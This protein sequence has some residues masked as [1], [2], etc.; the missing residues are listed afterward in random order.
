MNKTCT[1]CGTSKPLFSF[2]NHPKAADGLQSQ[3]KPCSLERQRIARV[4][5]PCNSCSQP[6]ESDA[7]KWARVCATC[8]TKCN[9]CG[10]LERVKNQRICAS[11]Q[12]D[13]DRERKSPEDAKIRERVTRIKTKYRA[14]PAFASALAVFRHCEACG[15][16][17]SR[18][19]EIHV[20]HCHDT[21]KIRG[22]L[23][24]NCNA[25][26]GHIGDS[27]DRLEMLI[28]YM[29][30]KKLF[31]DLSDLEKTKHY[32]DL[33]IQLEKENENL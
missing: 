12:A 29:K 13:K 28:L 19:G 17:A 2:G 6:I 1:K 16:K 25:A 21:G 26:L 10:K 4:G 27:I 20:D 22:V 5:R 30:E 31:K 14:R 18:A 8:K 15:K 7:K 24:F 3:C 32:L 11:C 9:S 23:C 33:L